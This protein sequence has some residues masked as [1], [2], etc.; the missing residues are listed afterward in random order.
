MQ[1]KL[2]AKEKWTM[3][4]AL[5]IAIPKSLPMPTKH[6]IV[7]RIYCIFILSIQHIFNNARPLHLHQFTARSKKQLENFLPVDICDCVV[8]GGNEVSFLKCFLLRQIILM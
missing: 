6:R 8:C 3:H 4:I 7:S 5:Q 1:H 2:R